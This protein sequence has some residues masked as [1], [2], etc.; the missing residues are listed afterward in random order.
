MMTLLTR[1]FTI[2][3][4]DRL[5]PLRFIDYR[6]ATRHPLPC[7]F[8]L[9]P[10]LAAYE[11]GIWYVPAGEAL[12]NGADHWLRRGLESCGLPQ[13]Y[14]APALV[15]LVFLAWSWL[16]RD[17][18]PDD[19]PGVCV[20]MAIES[21]AFGLGLWVLSRS[22]GTLT[23]WL[24][25]AVPAADGDRAFLQVVTY[26]GAGIYEEV[27]FRLL[28]FSGLLMVLRLVFSRWL[29]LPLAAL[30]SALLFAAAH[31]AGPYG[32]PYSD[33]V[34][35]FRVLAGLYFAALY[36]LRG[37]GIAVGAHVSY[38]VLVGVRM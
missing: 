25:L 5:G 14:W 3:P 32:E 26:I 36:Q 31:H 22:T 6:R 7:L 12:R 10:L 27:L 4:G 33:Q 23:H 20:G 11:V 34:F 17:E 38:D 37:F 9:I 15:G 24:Q 28:L 18:L 29:S 2:R 16:R 30:L 8:F 19:L 21:L 1:L 35:V 13:L